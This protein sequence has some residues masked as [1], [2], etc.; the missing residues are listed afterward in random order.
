V[1]STAFALLLT[2][3]IV[4]TVA[5]GSDHG[6]F[7]TVHLVERAMARASAAQRP[8]L[9]DAMLRKRALSALHQPQ[10]EEL[11]KHFQR[12]YE[13]SFAYL[14]EAVR[15]DGAR[16]LVCYIPGPPE[17]QWPSDANRSFLSGL[18]R[19][20]GVPLIDTTDALR[21]HPNATVYLLPED[22][23]L[24]RFGNQIVAA[25]LAPELEALAAHRG[26]PGGARAETDAPRRLGDLEPGTDRIDGDGWRA[27]SYRINRQG[28]RMPGDVRF[29]K[30]DAQ[31]VLLLGDS[32]TFGVYLPQEH[33]YAAFLRRRLEGRVVINAGRCGSTI[34]DETALYIERA[35]HSEPDIVV[36]QF[37][38]N[39]LID[40]F[41]YMRN[42][43]ARDRKTKT[44]SPTP[45]EQAF[46]ASVGIK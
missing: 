16:L 13:K 36:L 46:L 40:F 12:R 5:Y 35:R 7:A 20:Q 18:C 4:R 19:R 14:L 8:K 6:G 32:F 10:G 27:Y 3:V 22:M 24:S 44:C 25:T 1:I 11:L 29:P 33:T 34:E 17:W 42:Q 41:H 21:R 2:E 28:L 9:P 43:S 39:D 31:H 30:G 26:N 15:A 45:M 38:D 37:F 23:H